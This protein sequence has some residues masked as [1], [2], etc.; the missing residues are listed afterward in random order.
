MLLAFE[1]SCLTQESF[2]KENLKYR[3]LNQYHYFFIFFKE[4]NALAAK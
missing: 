3:R 1:S 2:L 4:I